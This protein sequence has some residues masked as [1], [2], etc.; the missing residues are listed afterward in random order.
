LKKHMTDEEIIENNIDKIRH[1]LE[2]QSPADAARILL[3]LHPA[4]QAELFNALNEDQRD[5]LMSELDVPATADLL[6][7]LE[8]DEVLEA[9]DILSTE[10]LADVLDEMEPDEAADLL[11]DL[12]AEQ[13]TEVLSQMEDAD[14]VLPLLGYPDETAGGLMTTWFIALRQHTTVA[15]AL[16]FLRQIKPEIEVPYYLYVVDRNKQLKGVVGLRQLVISPPDT[17]IETIADPEVIYI[18]STEDQEE[19]ARVMTRYD[20]ASLPVVDVE[21]R[22][23]GVITYDDIVDV[24]EA[25]ATEDIYRLANVSDADLEPESP[26]TEHIKGRLPWMYV[27]TLTALF[28]SW[29]VTHFK[30]I[31]AEVAVLAAFQSVVAGLGGNAGSQNVAMMVRAM[32]L[33]K[34]EPKL[35]W[36]NLR[37][38]VLVG[39]LQGL[40]VGLVVGICV[41]FWQHNPFLGLILGLAM[42]CNMTL[43][44]AIGT[45]VPFLLRMIGQDP[46]IASSILVTAATDSLGF[47]IFLGLAT[48]FLSYLR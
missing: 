18:S 7:E 10:R 29:V 33:G 21:N 32:A 44:G 4:D 6:Q 45:L 23:V 35:I 11:G 43:A 34:A 46:A 16:E 13:A 3:E 24:L 28:A 27:N 20:L 42:V 12:P 30:N 40:A 26:I 47:F 31:I 2:T 36:R 8:D 48:L 25:E 19:A 22:L 38:Q 5:L 17:K 14:E 41:G 37:K 1:I 39:F 9:V 15:Q